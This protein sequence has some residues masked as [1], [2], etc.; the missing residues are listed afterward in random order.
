MV[1]VELLRPCRQQFSGA[2]RSKELNFP[3]GGA[4]MRLC[5]VLCGVLLL[6]GRALTRSHPDGSV[7]IRNPDID[8]SWYTGRGIRPVG[9]FGRKAARRNERLAFIT[10]QVYRPA[11]DSERNVWILQ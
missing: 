11:A 1:L 10:S 8:A 2:L 9:R 6:L 3:A 7:I 4:A 5:A